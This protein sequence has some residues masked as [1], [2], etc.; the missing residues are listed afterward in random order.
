[1]GDILAGNFLKSLRLARQLEDEAKEVK[2]KAEEEAKK[3]RE[4][5]KKREGV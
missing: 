1:V 5:E 4:K 3:T 2:K